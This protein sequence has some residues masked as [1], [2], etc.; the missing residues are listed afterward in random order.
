M[1]IYLNAEES[2]GF[3]VLT[4]LKKVIRKGNS[5]VKYRY[6]EKLPIIIISISREY[7]LLRT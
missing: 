1:C 7:L 2:C 6:L 3:C 5:K 4:E